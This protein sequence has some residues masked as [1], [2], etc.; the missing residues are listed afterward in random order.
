MCE[1]VY[2]ISQLLYDMTKPMLFSYFFISSKKQSL[3]ALSIFMMGQGNRL[4]QGY[5]L[6]YLTKV[7]DWRLRMDKVHVVPTASSMIMVQA[8]H[9]NFAERF[10]VDTNDRFECGLPKSE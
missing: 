9:D 6:V 8:V 5:R 7:G 4:G 10:G 2:N 3:E 1:M